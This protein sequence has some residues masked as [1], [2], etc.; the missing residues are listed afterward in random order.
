MSLG[1]IVLLLP[2]ELSE[3]VVTKAEVGGPHTLCFLP[4][5]K[6]LHVT[7]PS[8]TTTS[9]KTQSVPYYLDFDPLK[10][11]I[12]QT[13]F[14]Y[15][16]LALCILLWWSKQIDWF[17]WQKE[18]RTKM[19]HTVIQVSSGSCWVCGNKITRSSS[20]PVYFCKV[21]T[22]LGFRCKTVSLTELSFMFPTVLFASTFILCVYV[23]RTCRCLCVF[24]LSKHLLIAC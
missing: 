2:T 20:C 16:S 1:N 17:K 19:R 11:C 22:I 10:L 6:I 3:R 5:Q 23:V 18:R 14:L 13:F 24:L 7:L 8:V 12:K 15:Q 4:S 9:V 21:K